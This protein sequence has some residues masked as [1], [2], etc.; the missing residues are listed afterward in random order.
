MAD[1]RADAV[2]LTGPPGSRATYQLT[3]QAASYIAYYSDG[4]CLVAR[5]HARHPD[6]LRVQNMIRTAGRPCAVVHT[7]VAAIRQIHDRA[8][9]NVDDNEA[10][11]RKALEIINQ[12]AGNNASDIHIYNHKQ[13]GTTV[14]FR[15]NGDLR[16]ILDADY[17]WGE[18]LA[19]AIY[20]SMTNVSDATYRPQARQDAQIAGF[21]GLPET[22]NGLR[23]GTAPLDH[24]STMILR[25]LYNLAPGDLDFGKLGYSPQQVETLDRMRRRS[26]GMTLIGGPTGSGKSTTL[27]YQLTKLGQETGGRKHILTIEDPPEYDIPTANQQPVANAE[28][29]AERT[30]AF[31][32]AIKS[33]MRQDPDVIMVGEVRDIPT[34]DLVVYGAMTGHHMLASVHSNTAAQSLDRL[35]ELQ[36]SHSLLFDPTIVTGLI[37]QRL[38]KTLCPHCKRPLTEIL[39][40]IPRHAI[41][42]WRR[43]LPFDSVYVEGPGCRRCEGKGT[44]GRQ[45]CAEIIEPDEPFM[46][47]YAA[48]EK[49]AAIEHWVRECGGETMLMRGVALV[50]KGIADPRAVEETIGLIEPTTAGEQDAIG[51]QDKEH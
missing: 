5:G 10:M 1:R 14:K 8:G 32:S 31:Q 21:A 16:T 13:R 49:T 50:R 28:T 17:E 35:S 12:A 15:I 11:Q 46:R 20:Q 44:A 43:A 4:T 47:H 51:S 37:C 3:R 42:R 25:L 34:A 19:R 33:A 39:D 7:D 27:Q 2:L 26:I 18:T 45:A 38:V 23:I 9:A 41:E 24:G 22:V 30:R 36:V 6:V 40:D 29:E 48:G